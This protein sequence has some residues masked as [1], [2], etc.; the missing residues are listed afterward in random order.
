MNGRQQLEVGCMHLLLTRTVS[1][2]QV[3]KYFDEDLFSVLGDEGRPDFRWLIMGPPRSGSTFHKDPNATSAW[4]AVV[5]GSKKWIMYPPHAL[6]PGHIS[7]N[8][9]LY[10][11]MYGVPFCEHERVREH[12]LQAA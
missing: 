10:H 8:P 12:M 2:M 1:V 4:N 9:L 7:S 3:P 5:T 11:Q 6:P